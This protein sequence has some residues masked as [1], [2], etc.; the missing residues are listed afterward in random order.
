MHLFA[1]IL[2]N[3]TSLATPVLNEI[4]DS[5]S[6][7]RSY[8][9]SVIGPSDEEGETDTKEQ[10]GYGSTL[11]RS[12][13]LQ[14]SHASTLETASGYDTAP[15]EQ[16]PLSARSPR[17]GSYQ[18]QEFRTPSTRSLR[19]VYSAQSGDSGGSV[20]RLRQPEEPAG[21]PYVIDYGSRS[22]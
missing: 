2:R 7:D 22:H 18:R 16:T 13:S 10:I 15:G 11:K 21:L 19:R 12:N 9:E 5:A 20:I 1:E 3:M 8:T 17:S 6:Y 14:P 4:R